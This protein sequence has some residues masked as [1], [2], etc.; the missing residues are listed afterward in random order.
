MQVN[1][2]CDI[3]NTGY[4]LRRNYFISSSKIYFHVFI[5]VIITNVGLNVYQT[6]KKMWY[7]HIIGSS[8]KNMKV[9]HLLQHDYRYIS[10]FLEKQIRYKNA[11]SILYYPHVNC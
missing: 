10:Q 7:I 8:G 2:S 5:V 3:L 1:L 9:W 6:M 11:G 4:T